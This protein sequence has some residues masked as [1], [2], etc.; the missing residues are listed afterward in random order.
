[1]STTE[2]ETE[3]PFDVTERTVDD[4]RDISSDEHSADELRALLN[5]ERNRTD[6]EPRS[7]AIEALEDAF[8]AATAGPDIDDAP[9]TDPSPAENTTGMD[10]DMEELAAN[11]GV[12]ERKRTPG[13]G[14][15]TAGLPGIVLPDPYG[16][17][18]PEE[19]R[20]AVPERMTFAG[21]FFD[22]PGEH[23]VEY[24]MRVK[25]A[26]E[27]ETNPVA[28]AANDP[29]HPDYDEESGPAGEPV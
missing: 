24:T 5:D 11:D 9:V 6:D 29:L 23:I 12:L 26:L 1:M 14:A 10:A 27:T 19:V 28:L 2:T 4:L 17:D 22:E 15:T 7:T 18:A 16:D 8:D 13:A 25:T 20:V 21:D 3:A